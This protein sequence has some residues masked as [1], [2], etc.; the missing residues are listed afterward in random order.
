MNT[1]PSRTEFFSVYPTTQKGK[2][3]TLLHPTPLSTTD[4]IRRYG[5][6]VR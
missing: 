4:S 5:E 3:N 6:K 2:P 1:E